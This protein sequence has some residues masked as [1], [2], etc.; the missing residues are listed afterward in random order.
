LRLTWYDDLVKAMPVERLWEL[1]S[2]K[3]VITWRRTLLPDTEI[4]YEEPTAE[5]TTYLHRLEHPLPRAFVVHRAAVLRGEQALQLLSDPDF[6]PLGTVVLEEEPGLVLGGSERA[7]N[8]TVSIVGYEHTR[9]ILD[10]E[11][12]SNGVLVL[13][14]VYYPGWRAYVDGSP[15]EIHRANHALR[16]VEVEEGTHRVQL[17]YD[18]LAPKVGGV[19]SAL[20]LAGV[21]VATLWSATRRKMA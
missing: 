10:V 16:A 8:S 17:V 21:L 3:Y 18:P 13:S 11:C 5:D 12:A 9:I 14:E 20:T 2:V 7:G 6:D 19:I 4:L 1:M 15:A